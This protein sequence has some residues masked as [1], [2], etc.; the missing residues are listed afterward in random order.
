MAQEGGGGEFLLREHCAVFLGEE[1]RG[2]MLELIR[3]ARSIG[4]L[5]SGT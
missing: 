4:L 1:G 2:D 5:C 3:G